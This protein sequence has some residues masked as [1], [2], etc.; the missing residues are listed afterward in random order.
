MSGNTI[1][2]PK[3]YTVE[4]QKI[5]DKFHKAI[6]K[7]GII[8]IGRKSKN[9]KEDYSHL[10][11][12][13]TTYKNVST[14]GYPQIYV[15]TIYPLHRISYIIHNDFKPIPENYYVCHKCDNR[16]CANPEHLYIDTP[17]QNNKDSIERSRTKK[18]QE[19]KVLKNNINRCNHCKDDD[20]HQKCDGGFPCTYC[21]K[22][23]YTDC[24]PRQP[25]VIIRK[26]TNI[27]ETNPNCKLTDAQVQNLRSREKKHGD[28]I[29]W[30]K[31][32]N[33]TKETIRNI[34]KGKYRA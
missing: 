9:E 26:G 27:G 3:K 8:N 23:G 33:V 31:E 17:S 18:V 34:L 7:N 2:E 12:C 32:F 30:A 11:Q 25:T 4:Q 6:D 5:L 14:S 10:T 22:K 16:L 29:K 15:D 13:W 24:T 21:I 28:I 1:E 19:P 20:S